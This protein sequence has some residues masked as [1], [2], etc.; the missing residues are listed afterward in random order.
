VRV[1]AAYDVQ[2]DRARGDGLC[3]AQTDRAR[4]ACAFYGVQTDRA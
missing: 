4:V 3:D 1:V 2:T